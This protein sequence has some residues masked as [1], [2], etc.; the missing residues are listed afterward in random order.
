M[1]PKNIYTIYIND[2]DK[3]MSLLSD[4]NKMIGYAKYFIPFNCLY[5]VIRYKNN[6]IEFHTHD[7][8]CYR[9]HTFPIDVRLD[10]KERV[11]LYYHKKKNY[12]FVIDHSDWENVKY[13]KV[14]EKKYG[15]MF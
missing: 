5:C 7:N 8:V 1:K 12:L 10:K 6:S 4:Y 2:Y 15:S 13:H 9:R 14:D 3:F 11:E